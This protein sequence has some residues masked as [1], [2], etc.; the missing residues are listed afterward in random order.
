MNDHSSQP[1]PARLDRFVVL[2]GIDG[3]GTTTQ[4]K[5]LAERLA[6]AGIAAWLTSEPTDRPMGVVAREVLS[7]RLAVAPET[8][9]YV[10]AADRSDHLFHADG[11]VSHLERGELVICDRYVYSSLAYQSIEA[12]PTLVASLNGRFPDPALVLFLDLPVEAVEER[13]AAR[14]EREIYEHLA[15][16][17]RVRERY[18]A[19]LAE[20]S[21][22]T[23]VEMI[24]ATMPAE[25]V[26]RKI[27]R[28][29]EE[30]SI[31]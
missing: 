24:D 23:A 30:R 27:W 2:E 7:G 31:L 20:A 11:V 5:L 10:F 28:A 12:D 15:F 4:M 3:A 17:E 9:A 13:L 29:M 1:P 16:Q 19:V 22:R 8:V 26:T 6:G 18:L 25:E 21:T 14:R